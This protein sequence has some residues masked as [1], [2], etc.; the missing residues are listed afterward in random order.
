MAIDVILYLAFLFL[1]YYFY[2]LFLSINERG[3]FCSDISIRKELKA[4]TI[5]S[6]VLLIITLG[7]PLPI[8]FITNMFIEKKELIP[9]E[10]LIIGANPW[11]ESI[12][13]TST[14]VYLDYVIGFFLLTLFLDFIKCYVGRLRPNF[15]EMCR[16]NNLFICNENPNAFI[17]HF[18]CTST[19]KY[20]RNSRLILITIFFVF[21]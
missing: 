7:F 14:F 21:F 3:F 9:K 12:I 10:K 5:S 1:I 19:W 16:P 20:S 13:K 15:I 2:V 6:N 11:W 17:S 18:K 4:N 8:I